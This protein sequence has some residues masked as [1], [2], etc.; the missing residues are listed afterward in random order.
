MGSHMTYSYEYWDT[1]HK[2]GYECKRCGFSVLA[3]ENCPYCEYTEAEKMLKEL[4]VE[5]IR[6]GKV[7]AANAIEIVLAGDPSER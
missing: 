1:G 2:Q 3:D 5:L 7:N 6:Q 4:R